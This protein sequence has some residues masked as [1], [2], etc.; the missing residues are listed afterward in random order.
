MQQVKNERPDSAQTMDLYTFKVLSA[1]HNSVDN[2][3]ANEVANIKTSI[4]TDESQ[5]ET[6]FAENEAVSQSLEMYNAALDEPNL[7]N[8]AQV[9]DN[10]RDSLKNGIQGI[11][12]VSN[13][14]NQSQQPTSATSTTTT[15]TTTTTSTSPSSTNITDTNRTTTTT[16]TPPSSSISAVDL[17]PDS[18][19]QFFKCGETPDT[20]SPT[21]P[22]LDVQ[23]SAYSAITDG[24]VNTEI[25]GRA[26]FDVTF[27]Q[28]ITNG[29]GPDL[30]MYE[31]GNSPE[32]FN[33]TL[34]SGDILTQSIEY[35]AVTSATGET[36]DCGFVVNTAEIDLSDFGLGEEQAGSEEIIAV[37]GIR[38]DNLGAEGCCTGADIS[39]VVIVSPASATITEDV[40]L[41]AEQQQQQQDEDEPNTEGEGE[42]IQSPSDSEGNNI[43]PEQEAED[44]EQDGSDE[45]DEEEE[46]E[47]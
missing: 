23:S 8:A 16:T 4:V 36:D 44:A 42:G 37:T 17:H 39:D 11:R 41:L 18:V 27:S 2:T 34:F 45:A 24:D 47:E 40:P 38:V 6:L 3:L 35:S 20:G 21:L 9:V 19:P 25:L 13:T 7:T 5:L 46:S 31:I 26:I 32:P 29:P 30:L 12:E 10:F 1:L 14:L 43:E 28:P 33:I 15:N 22:G